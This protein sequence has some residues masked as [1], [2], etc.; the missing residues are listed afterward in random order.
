MPIRVRIA[1]V[2]LLMWGA[3][4]VA[5]RLGVGGPPLGADAVEALFA[6]F[7]F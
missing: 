3:L 7:D 4:Y 2:L 6:P 5:Y 1:R